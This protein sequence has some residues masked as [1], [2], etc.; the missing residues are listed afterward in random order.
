MPISLI[1]IIKQSGRDATSSDFFFMLDSGDINFKIQGI[2]EDATLNPTLT[3]DNKYILEDVSALNA[4]FGT[5][6]GVGDNDIVRYNGTDF[7]IFLDASNKQ[8]GTI[9]FNEGDSKFYGFNGTAW[10]ELGSGAGGGATGATGATG[11]DS[12][13]AGPTGAD[14]TVA[15]PAGV[16]GITG[17]TGADSTV[18]GPAGVTGLTGPTGPKGDDGTSVSIEG[19]VA[20]TGDLPNGKAEGVLFI[21]LADGDGYLSNGDDT[22][23]NVGPLRGPIGNTG[24]AGATGITGP[25]GAD[26]TVAGPI[27]ATGITGPT[28]ADS[29]VAGPIGATGITGPTGAD[30]TVAGPAGVT[31]ITGPTGADSTVAG[32]IGATGITG[33]TGADSTV[34]GPAGAT[35]ITGPTGADS[36]VAGPIGATGITGPTGADSTVAGPAGVTGITGPTGADSTVAGPIGVTGPTGEDGTNGSD[37]AT[38]NTGNDGPRGNTGATG[39]VDLSFTGGVPAGASA[40]DLWFDSTAGVFSVY[41][42]DGDSQ[43]WVELAGKQGPTGATG[44]GTSGGGVTVTAS[45]GTTT[46]SMFYDTT[47]SVFINSENFQLTPSGI[48]F[49]TQFGETI[50]DWGGVT[51]GA[52]FEIDLSDGMIQ[53]INVGP[54]GGTGDGSTK[55]FSFTGENGSV[56]ENVMLVIRGGG[57]YTMDF[58]DVT[59]NDEAGEPAFGSTAGTWTFV[60]FTY[61]PIDGLGW[62]GG[63]QMTVVQ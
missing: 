55:T 12:T 25:T 59:W 8:D 61:I 3:T 15:G 26:S 35:G 62:V 42:D 23:D 51:T 1:D 39:A 18:A 10:Q 60:P 32:P 22:W 20:V 41:I 31:G 49:F 5:I 11:A 17:P 30:S 33:P 63:A 7:E 37:G 29:T 6:T 52:T 44:A 36:T 2:Q 27:G 16:T 50:Y 9:V 38:G 14:S 24:P 58:S 56:V 40:G 46:D 34:A 53:H 47:S 54:T 57:G 28:G 21:V 4:N 19:S 13:V 43:Q 45:T 48:P